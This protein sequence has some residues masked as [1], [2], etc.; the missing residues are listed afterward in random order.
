MLDAATRRNLELDTHASGNRE[1]TL[2]GVLDRTITPM[3]ARLLRRWLH[4]PLRDHGVLNRRQQAIDALIDQRGYE[5]LREILRGIGDLERILAR[6]ALRSARPRDLSTLRDG[7]LAAPALRNALAGSD[8][9]LLH[10]SCSTNL[11]RAQHDSA[12][13]WPQR[14]R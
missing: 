4:R 2:L 1:F 8:S 14:A 10:A 5:G 9:P 3:G 12:R 11:R 7:L 6:V 13:I